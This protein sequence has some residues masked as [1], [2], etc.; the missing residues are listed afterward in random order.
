MAR[1]GCFSGIAAVFALL[2]IPASAMQPELAAPYRDYTLPLVTYAPLPSRAAGVLLHARINGGPLLRLL[3]DS[4]A[5]DIVLDAK[6]AHRSGLSTSSGVIMV[7][8]GGAPTKTMKAG[9]ARTVEIGPLA[10]RNYPVDVAP[11]KLGEGLDGVVP[12]SIFGGFLVRLDLPRKV[13]ELTSYPERTPASTEAFARAL[14]AGNLLFVPATID[15][16]GNGYL[17]IDTGSSYTAISR[18]VARSLR[19]AFIAF[20]S[21]RGGDGLVNG[22]FINSVRFRIAG[23]ELEAGQVVALDL[24]A[25]SRYSDV[26]V[27]GLLGYPDLRSKV[28]TID[29]RDS[30]VKIEP[31]TR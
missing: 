3:L 1:Y 5:A 30:L 18:S 2:A 28:L 25:L 23:R 4:G 8:A 29:Y 6:T 10:F 19:S 22:E 20:A 26:E 13:M 17:L 15:R 14:P 9:L 21:I 7:C 27:A 31:G 16:A 11:D 24:T 12:I